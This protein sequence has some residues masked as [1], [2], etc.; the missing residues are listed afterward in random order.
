MN[1]TPATISELKVAV[2]KLEVLAML[3][4]KTNNLSVV[5]LDAFSMLM[6]EQCETLHAGLAY[7]EQQALA[8]N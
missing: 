5:Q 2:E 8:I 4:E 3:A 7:L 1:L 6:V